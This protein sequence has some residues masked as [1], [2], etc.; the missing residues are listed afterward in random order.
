[1]IVAPG[2]PPDSPLTMEDVVASPAYRELRTAKISVGDSAFL[3]ELPTFG[4]SG[5]IRLAD[6]AAR[7]PVALVFGSYT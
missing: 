3:F 1:M 4:G 5:V 7:A 6:L 2:T